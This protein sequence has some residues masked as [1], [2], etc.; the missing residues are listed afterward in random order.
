MS[1]IPF[2]IS[3]EVG[4]GHVDFVWHHHGVRVVLIGVDV[5]VGRDD[6]GAVLGVLVGDEG[7]GDD[8]GDVV[9]GHQDVNELPALLVRFLVVHCGR[10]E[11]SCKLID[12]RGTF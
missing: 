6:V 12:Y 3:R 1:D 10:R 8:H 4:S 2:Y 7:V 11:L 9:D 5:G